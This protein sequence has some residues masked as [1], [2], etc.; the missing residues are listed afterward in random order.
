MPRRSARQA[1]L[2]RRARSEIDGG[3]A[4]E[5]SWAGQ[6][7]AEEQH[8]P[9]AGNH[10]RVPAGLD[11]PDAPA[12]AYMPPGARHGRGGARQSPMPV[13]VPPAGH[14]NLPLPPFQSPDAL[15]VARV[16]PLIGM[17]RSQHSASVMTQADL[18]RWHQHGRMFMSSLKI[19]PFGEVPM[20]SDAQQKLLVWLKNTAAALV[21]YRATSLEH[22][23]MILQKLTD[24]IQ[25]AA[26]LTWDA[27][28]ESAVLEQPL[29][30]SCRDVGTSSLI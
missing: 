15:A 16:V 7:E 19:H 24:A 30:G 14:R 8:L 22:E 10:G 5:S 26:K 13:H 29:T 25:P 21:A 6:M 12:A 4:S 1:A 2:A 28:V 27:A 23:D 18:D 3:S 9:G 17:V 20:T 11:A